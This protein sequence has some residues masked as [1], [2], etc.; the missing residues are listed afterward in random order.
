MIKEELRRTS[1]FLREQFSAVPYKMG[2]RK[3]KKKRICLTYK[4]IIMLFPWLPPRKFPGGPK[5]KAALPGKLS[6]SPINRAQPEEIA[7]AAMDTTQCCCA[8]WPGSVVYTP[9]D[10]PTA[11][12]AQMRK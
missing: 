1:G 9:V 10:W 3:M 7:Y 5:R 2:L 4:Q 11:P 6:L 12:T 8:V